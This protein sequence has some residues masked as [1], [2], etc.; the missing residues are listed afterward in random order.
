MRFDRTAILDWSAAGSPKGGKDSIWLGVTDATGTT[1][2]NHRTRALAEAALAALCRDTLAQGQTLLLGADFNFGAPQGF[3]SQLTGSATALALWRWLAER[4]QD[5]PQ[6]QTNYR[7]VAAL[8]NAAFPGGGPFWGNGAKDETPGLPRTKP[9]LPPGLSEHRMTDRIGQTGGLWPK[10]IWQLAGAGAVGA[11][12]LTGLPV[13][14]RLREALGGACTVWPFEAPASPIV[15][16]E[17]YASHIAPQV[18]LLEARGMIRDEAQVRLLSRA[19]YR[20]GSEAGL[21]PLFA[22]DIPRPLLAEEGWTL[23]NGHLDTLRQAVKPG[24]AG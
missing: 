15:L 18:A 22:P 19:L 4:V 12:S 17:I 10:P 11:Q 8:A 16:A 13:L 1:A 21:A 6:N 9:A 14:W 5:S 20:L 3:A 2:S 24:D 7:A 23:G